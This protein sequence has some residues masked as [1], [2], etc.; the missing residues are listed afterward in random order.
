MIPELYIIHCK[1]PLFAGN[2]KSNNDLIDEPIQRDSLDNLPCIYA[3]NLKGIF[4]R[5]FEEGLKEKMNN[6]YPK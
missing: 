2:G 4:R 5:H 6:E 1:S 3:T